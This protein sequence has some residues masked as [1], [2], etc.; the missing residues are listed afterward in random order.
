M[1]IENVLTSAFTLHLFSITYRLY[2]STSFSL[3]SSLSE[4]FYTWRRF[5]HNI[6][7]LT[8]Q[9]NFTSSIL[10]HEYLQSLHMHLDN[11]L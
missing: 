5:G 1:H 10:S 2:T 11:S 6:N 8:K 4:L 9:Q 7:T 3:S